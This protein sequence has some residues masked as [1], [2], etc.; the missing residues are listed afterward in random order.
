M[1]GEFTS[2]VA[3]FVVTDASQ[4]QLLNSVDLSTVNKVFR[5]EK[6]PDFVTDRYTNDVF[7]PLWRKDIVF[8][9]SYVEPTQLIASFFVLKIKREKSGFWD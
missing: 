2:G 4:L 3:D 1:K 6:M 5:T 9:V 7:L 8:Y